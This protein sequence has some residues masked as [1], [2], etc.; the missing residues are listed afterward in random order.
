MTQ[1]VN[2]YLAEFRAKK[3]AL[4]V[5]LMGQVLGGVVVLMLL[6]SAYDYFVRWSLDGE[7]AELR[8]VLQE[9]SQKT[10]ELNGLL[11]QRSQSEQL[12]LRLEEAEERLIADRQVIDFLGRT[13]LGS[14]QGFSEHFKDLSRASMDGFSLS[15]VSIS[16]GGQQVALSGQVADSSLVVRFV[17]NLEQG[18]SSMRDFSFSTSI[19]RADVDGKTF[20]F[21]LR[22]TR[23]R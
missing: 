12:T 3:D 6:V 1:Q 15:A 20:P 13:N 14:L 10:S 5:L 17:S 23:E 11:A 18:Q 8:L 4:T 16:N 21:E 19:T 7:L 2:L 22:S 9:E